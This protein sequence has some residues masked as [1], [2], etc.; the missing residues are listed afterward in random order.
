MIHISDMKGRTAL[1]YASSADFDA[2]R[3]KQVVEKCVE[4]LLRQVHYDIPPPS[5]KL[6]SKLHYDFLTLALAND[7]GTLHLQ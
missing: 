6:I 5:N 2:E 1:H 4:T 7:F 3:T